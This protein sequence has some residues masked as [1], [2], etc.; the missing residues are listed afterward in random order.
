[1]G[2][3]S[4]GTYTKGVP[5]FVPGTVIDAG[6]VNTQFDDVGTELTDSLS[7]TGKGG[8]LARWRGVDGTSALPA[9]AFTSETTLGL[10]RAA[11]GDLRASSNGTDIQ[12]WSSTG[13][14]VYQ[15]AL[16]EKGVVVTNSTTNG[17]ALTATG[18]GNGAGL[19]GIGG[20]T[21]NGVT[22]TGGATGGVGGSFQGTGSSVGVLGVG[23]P[24]SRG[25]SFTGGSGNA[26]GVDGFGTGS[27]AGVTGVGGATGAGVSGTG[28]ATGG[29]GGAFTGTGSSAG[30]TG[31]GAAG[32][33]GLLGTGG[34]DAA[35]VQGVGTGN[36]AG[37]TFTG[38]ATGAGLTATGGASGGAGGVFTGTSGASGISAT[39][40]GA[41]HGMIAAGGASGA[42]VRATAGTAATGSTPSSAIILR[43]GYL[44]FDGVTAPDATT[45]ISNTVTPANILKAS[46]KVTVTGG[47]ATLNGGFNV[48]S[49][50]RSGTDLL[51][52]WA[53][54]FTTT[55]YVPTVST[56]HT[57]AHARVVSQAEG[58]VVVGLA[59]S[60]DLAA[61]DA[62]FYV[63]CSG[64]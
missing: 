27:G 25:G 19:V 48:T 61:N 56:N 24:N 59:N 29:V 2:R 3:N 10:Y 30:A 55:D 34:S 47:V 53:Q 38:G 9:Y 51:I 16:F 21:G 43:D 1:M 7:R 44:S 62:I 40:N 4:T 52:T 60:L 36:G 46:A 49:A 17:S 22:A 23:A 28:G 64:L 45:A 35:G 26:G 20:A 42:G 33:V 32:A 8:M 15:A 13:V 37:G 31:T 11:S 18:N 50:V 41:G 54:D 12:K 39:G 57:T 14:T 63:S 58:T 6:D 5:S